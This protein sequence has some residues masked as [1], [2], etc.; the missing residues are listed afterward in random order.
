M[1]NVLE[2]AFDVVEVPLLRVRQK[3]PEP[4]I[5]PHRRREYI[6]TPAL[7]TVGADS[8]R[9]SGLSLYTELP[10]YD[11]ILHSKPIHVTEL[12]PVWECHEFYCG[13]IQ[14]NYLAIELESPHRLT[15]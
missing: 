8:Y 11:R 15:N 9:Y 6:G 5:D 1:R 10:F 14:H 4:H 13:H 2:E 7:D 3:K 12:L